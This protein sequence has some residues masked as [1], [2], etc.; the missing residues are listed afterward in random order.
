[1]EKLNAELMPRGIT[2]RQAQVL[3]L[4]PVD[5]AP[6][7]G[8]GHVLA[9]G[10]ATYDPTAAGALIAST[11]AGASRNLV[12]RMLVTLAGTKDRKSVV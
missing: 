4:E 2:F 11:R 12:P 7:L 10:D 9:D 1:M 8:D 6:E 3:G 5:L